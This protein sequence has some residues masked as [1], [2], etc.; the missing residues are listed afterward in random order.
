MNPLVQFIKTHP[1]AKLPS[2]SYAL[3]VGADISTIESFHIYHGKTCI[4]DTGLQLAYCDPNFEIQ[5]RSRSGLAAK[6]GIRVTNSPGTIDPGYRGPIKIILSCDA[7]DHQLDE[8]FSWFSQGDRIA[9]L[10]VAPR[11]KAFFEF[12]DKEIPADDSRGLGGFG[13]TGV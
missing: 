1:E 10:V 7:G 2:Y 9:Q 11:V 8:P 3:D 4:V 13:S 6:H 12:T 5:I